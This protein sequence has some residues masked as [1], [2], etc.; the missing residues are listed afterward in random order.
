[1]RLY[2]QA[3]YHALSAAWKST[4]STTTKAFLQTPVNTWQMVN[5]SL[6]INRPVGLAFKIPLDNLWFP[7]N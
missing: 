3:K 6:I 5:K 1:V 4:I 2:G 7:K